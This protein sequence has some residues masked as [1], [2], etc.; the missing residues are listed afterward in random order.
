[1]RDH[2]TPLDAPGDVAPPERAPHLP[3][4]TQRAD[5]SALFELT[6]AATTT[7]RTSVCYA[8]FVSFLKSRGGRLRLPRPR[9]RPHPSLG[10]VVD[11]RARLAP[12][13]Q[14]LALWT[15]ETR[16]GA[17]GAVASSALAARANALPPHYALQAL[18]Y[19][20]GHARLAMAAPPLTPSQSVMADSSRLAADQPVAS[21]RPASLNAFRRKSQV[22]RNE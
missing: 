19:I 10:G 18:G 6:A 2:T 13:A 4:G 12:A 21:E 16:G 8:E 9:L 20:V 11:E 22:Q 7:R 1:M 14:A 3:T 5:R 15:C 17:A